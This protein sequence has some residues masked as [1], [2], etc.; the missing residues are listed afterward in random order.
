MP[1]INSCTPVIFD[2]DGTLVDSL[3][4]ITAAVQQ[5]LRSH[6]EVITADQVRGLIGP[7]IRDV[8]RNIAV[9]ASDGQ[10]RV[11]EQEFRA[12]YDS[13]EWRST[14]LFS[15]ARETLEEL[16]HLTV[17]LF[18]FTNKPEK[19]VTRIVKALD[20]DGF[21]VDRFSKDSREP[22]FENKAQMLRELM[23]KHS[24]SPEE[25]VVVGDGQEDY[26]AARQLRVRFVFA[27]YGYGR[28]GLQDTTFPIREIDTLSALL[29]L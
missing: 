25:C 29:A 15:S 22:A 5:A 8:L 26:H 19:A 12:T 17:P 9:S 4:G 3:P 14:T 6:N 7:P 28:L 21:F 13:S 23:V 10:I 18:L 27:K 11:A 1:L 2:L 16:L 24:V 20:L